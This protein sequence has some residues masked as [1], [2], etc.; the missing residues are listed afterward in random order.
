MDRQSVGG[1]AEIVLAIVG[2]IRRIRIIIVN[3]STDP[4]GQCFIKDWLQ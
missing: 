1:T 4:A 2:S 3:C